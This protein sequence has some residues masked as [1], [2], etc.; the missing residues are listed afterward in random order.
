MDNTKKVYYYQGEAVKDTKELTWP[1][2]YEDFIKDIIQNFDLTNKNILVILKVVTDDGDENNI[3]SQEDLEEYLEDDNIKE[4]KFS[5]EENKDSGGTKNQGPI[6]IKEFEKLLDPNLLKEEE[7]LDVDNILKDMFDKDEYTRKKKEEE[8]KYSDIFNQS[9]EKSMEEILIQQ[10]KT[11]EEEINKK[12]N[13]YSELFAKDQREAYNS[14]MDIKDNLVNIKDQ[15]E[16]M[17]GA[18]KE[19]R[20]SI[21]NNQLVLASYQKINQ[22][23]VKKDNNNN[24][25][26]NNNNLHM[27]KIKNNNNFAN[28][29]DNIMNEREED[30]ISIKFEKRKMEITQDVKEAKFLNID[31]IRMTNEGIHSYKNLCFV[32]DEENSSEEINF[33]GHNKHTDIFELTMAGE[34]EP[35]SNANFN[36]SVAINNPKPEQIYKM[37]IYVREKNSNKNLSEPLE[38]IVKTKQ[39]EDPIQ[40]RQKRAEAI[41]EDLKNEF[42]D[43]ENLVDK[44][45]IINQL[46]ENDLDKEAIKKSLNAKIQEIKEKQ[47]NEKSEQIFKELEF[48]GF[49][50]G[51]EQMISLIKENNFNKENVQNYINERISEQIY[52]N[53]SKSD[54][55]DFKN[56]SKED[57]LNKIKEL[58]FNVDGIKEVYKK[59]KLVDPIVNPANEGGNEGGNGDDEEVDKLYQELEDEYGISGFIEEEAAKAKIR[60]LN[61]NRDQIVDWIE[62]NLLNGDN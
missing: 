4:F 46:L 62:N 21:Q 12:L 19:L 57:V 3:N 5:I 26:N 13:N 18:I 52:D 50:F 28:P 45:E 29:L 36:I 56:N 17:S 10:S 27:S 53:L 2:K 7:D 9:L 31:N 30:E 24:N 8:N 54:D 55:V 15:T 41:Y 37:V 40:Q 38:I 47:N 23:K 35:N 48:Y 33:L 25:N 42:H 60:E 16:E 11:M 39:A 49:N 59:G 1:Q 61:C 43:Y 44:N 14:I 20:D 32:K 58:N 51:K 22:I 6:N 34:F